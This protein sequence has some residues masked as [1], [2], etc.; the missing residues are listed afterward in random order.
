MLISFISCNKTDNDTQDPNVHVE[1]MDD[2]V[3]TD[4][5]EFN[6]SD[7]ISVEITAL[8]N[9]DNPIKGVKFTVFGVFEDSDSSLLIRGFTNADGIFSGKFK[10]AT[11]L[12]SLYIGTNFIGLP[13]GKTIAVNSENLKVTFGGKSAKK[14]SGFKSIQAPSSAVFSYLGG[15]DWQ[16]VPDYL[17]D[18]DIITSG[19]LSEVNATLPEEYPVTSIHPE[20]LASGN[21]I[22]TNIIATSDVW[23]TFVHE[24]AGYKN[25]LGFYTYPTNDPP[26]TVQEIDTIHIAFPNLSFLYAG[27]GLTSGNKVHLGTF[28]P[29][30]TIAWVIIAN[31][32]NGSGVN[33]NSPRYYSNQYFNPESSELTRQHNVILWDAVSERYIVGFED[34][35]RDGWCDEDFNDAIFYV[36]SNPVEGIDNSNTI[37]F[38]PEQ[39]DSDGDGVSDDNDDYPSDPDKAI[40]SYYPSSATYGNLAFEDL[41]PQKGDYDFNDMVL[42]YRYLQIQNGDNDVVEIQAEFNV[43]AVGAGFKNGFG[44]EIPISP[45]LVSSVSGINTDHGLVT[46]N[47]NGTEA[48]QDNAVIIVFDNVY[49]IFP[50]VSH[51]YINTREDMGFVPHET[52]NVSIVLTQPVP[53]ENLGIPSYNPFI[54]IDETRGREVHLPDFNPT[55]LVDNSYF[56]TEDDNSN[57]GAGRYYKT[58]N[59]MPWAMDLSE[60]FAYPKETKEI[61]DGHL[62]FDLWVLS[63]GTDYNDWY[64]DRSN[65]RDDSNLYNPPLK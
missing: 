21:D 65:Y 55:N 64:K 32:W 1:S 40:N 50:T 10:Y 8:D 36:T 2:L 15:F 12:D 24:G 29:G 51:G 56:N 6:N 41:W 23:I 53:S 46:L 61:I 37:I 16:G 63:S 9:G 60:N 52:I 25:S 22:N 26:P 44:F 47:S 48:G 18:D 62:N 57:P 59:N 34:L 31:G 5:F 4:F 30:T 19:F 3:A 14:S 38:D 39:T 7:E 49:N 17:V 54:F 43:K 35:N 28:P 42:E 45:N 27:G 11:Y 20:Y 13:N 33:P 58:G